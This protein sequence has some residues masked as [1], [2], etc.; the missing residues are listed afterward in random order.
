SL[1]CLPSQPLRETKS[2]P[3]CLTVILE[4]RDTIHSRRMSPKI[5]TVRTTCGRRF[6]ETTGPMEDLGTAP[7]QEVMSFGWQDIGTGLQPRCVRQ[8]ERD[9]LRFDHTTP[10]AV[11]AGDCVC[12]RGEQPK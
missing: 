12:C 5:Q 4:R 3:G 9:T 1:A 10:S 8:L 6:R 2:L 7:I 11:I